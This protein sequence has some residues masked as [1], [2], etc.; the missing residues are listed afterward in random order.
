LEW[1]TIPFDPLDSN[2]FGKLETAAITGA[3]G[4]LDDRL[5]RKD[6][7]RRRETSIGVTS[8]V[9]LSGYG[10]PTPNSRNNP[11]EL[12]NHDPTLQPS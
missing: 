9:S 2:T 3:L 5:V 4:S 12:R 10:Q 11:I 8:P 6:M 1:Q 7:V